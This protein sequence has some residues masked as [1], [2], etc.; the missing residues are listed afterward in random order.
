MH[1]VHGF[2]NIPPTMFEHT[3]NMKRENMDRVQPSYMCRQLSYDPR[4]HCPI[5]WC[6]VLRQNVAGYAELEGSERVVI[7]LPRAGR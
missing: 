2:Y 4:Y 5:T 7:V 6:S 3:T 1:S